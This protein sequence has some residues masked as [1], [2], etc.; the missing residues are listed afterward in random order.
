MLT[1]VYI[2]NL[3]ATANVIIAPTALDLAD[4]QRS[5]ANAREGCN[6]CSR[7]MVGSSLTSGAW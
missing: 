6:G 2:S 4:Y 1:H 7:F 5:G 3:R